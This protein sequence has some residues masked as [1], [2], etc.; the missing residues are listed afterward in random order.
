MAMLRKATFASCLGALL[1]GFGACSSS[2]A[3]DGGST[4]ATCAAN[5][6][7]HAQC[8]GS[9]AAASI[10]FDYRMSKRFDLYAGSMWS[11]VQDGLA[12]GYLNKDNIATTVGVRF[13]F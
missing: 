3:G 1:L 2:P 6:T 7:S 10:V 13:K 5:E 11:G 9:E 8:S 12:N 4:G